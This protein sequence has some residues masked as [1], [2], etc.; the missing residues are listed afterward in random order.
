MI[1]CDHNLYT[2]AV[3]NIWYSLCKVSAG[4]KLKN[5]EARVL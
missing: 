5:N 3:C 1:D 2:S 4:D